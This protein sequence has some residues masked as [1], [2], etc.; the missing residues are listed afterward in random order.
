MENTRDNL[1]TANLTGVGQIMLQENK[2]TGLLFLA[3]I[4]YGSWVMGLAVVLST[5][6]GTL[7]AKL[8]R[9][10][11]N[12]IN[13]GLYGF[14]AALVGAALTFYFNAGALVWVGIVVGSAVSS[15]LMHVALTRKI[16]VYTFPFI[17]TTWV[18]V[19]LLLHVAGVP[20]QQQ[21]PINEQ[22]TDALTVASHG[23]GEVIFQGS[24]VA[25]AIFFIAIFINSPI[26][27][28]YGLLGAIIG[29]SVSHYFH[30]PMAEVNFG[31]FSFNAV[32][33]AIAFAGDKPK[34][35]IF[36][37]I[38]TAL[39]VVIDVLMVKY[40]LIPLTFPFVLASWITLLA[41]RAALA[42]RP[43][44]SIEG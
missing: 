18:L 9:Y 37:F 29:V 38:A 10:N 7:T 22:Y 42:I 15:V 27:A 2:W 3:G 31:L 28:L 6:V 34:D 17:A 33:C 12:E 13:S 19:F 23:F 32:L 21:P 4:W 25:G 35:G 30:E 41:K 36:V 40:S 39:S 44:R 24:V 8:L 14:N 11:D 1:L 26:S 43:A 16:P 5:L 20:Y